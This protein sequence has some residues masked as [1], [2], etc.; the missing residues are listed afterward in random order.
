MHRF[1]FFV[2]CDSLMHGRAWSSHYLI[3]LYI[4]FVDEIVVTVP[5][6]IVFNR[7]KKF[8]FTIYLIAQIS[9]FYLLNRWN[10]CTIA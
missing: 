5:K 7:F 9:D 2:V 4:L 10:Y 3:F 1:M 8:L 6:V